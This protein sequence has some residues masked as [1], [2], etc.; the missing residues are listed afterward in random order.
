L[1]TQAGTIGEQGLILPPALNLTSERLER[2]GLFMIEDG[3]NIFLWVGQ[4]AVPQLIMDVFDLP[5]YGELK[6]GKV[7]PCAGA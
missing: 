2:H 6:G 5:N 1:I 4:E 3:Q 7:S